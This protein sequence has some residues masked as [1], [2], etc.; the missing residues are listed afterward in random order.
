VLV[1]LVLIGV[2]NNYTSYFVSAM[3]DYRQS[4]LPHRQAGQI[5]RGFI[6]S[7]GAP[8]NA[9]MLAYRYW[10]DHRAVAIESGDPSWPN[11]IADTSNLPVNIIAFMQ[12][13]QGS[14]YALRADR[15]LL[16]FVNQEDIPSQGTLKDMFPQGQLMKI[17]S[18]NSTRDFYIFVAPAVGCQWAMEKI[19][20]TFRECPTDAA[21]TPTPP[22]P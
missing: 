17:A 19:G 5:L 21:P 20:G 7:T 1:L 18:Y 16:F 15:Q 11:G 8:G 13:N 12:S 6:D 10:W 9:F 4:T 14:K 3:G 22:G 2:Y